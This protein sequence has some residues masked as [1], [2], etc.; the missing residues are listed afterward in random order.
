MASR[1]EMLRLDDVHIS[2]TEL[3]TQEERAIRHRGM[4]NEEPHER[5]VIYLSQSR[6]YGAT[7]LRRFKVMS[8][9]MST[10]IERWRPETYTFHFSCG[11][12][13]ITL[14]DVVYQLGV[15]INGMPLV[16][17]NTYSLNVDFSNLL[18]KEAPADVI[19]GLRIQMN[20]E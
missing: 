8:A 4:T 2:S 15:L 14:E 10:L 9:L 18:G 20:L 13:T 12:V 7:F 16:L 19:D 11:E 5:I 6:L 1:E 17:R 3:T